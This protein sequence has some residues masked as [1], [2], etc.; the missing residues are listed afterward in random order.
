[1]QSCNRLEISPS[2][3]RWGFWPA[4]LAGALGGFLAFILS[5]CGTAPA[6]PDATGRPTAPPTLGHRIVAEARQLIG[7]PYRYGGTTPRGFDC[8]GLVYYTHRR[9]G[10]SVPR[11]TRA[12][13]DQARPVLPGRLRPGDLVFFRLSWRKVSHV[14]IY[15][16]KGRFIHAPSSGKRVSMASLDNEYWEKRLVAAGRFYG[17]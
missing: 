5:G 2:N 11:S 8:S 9:V 13:L 10:L 4:F 14:G 15:A 7:T 1:M 6:T 16:G 12:Q 17:S 3:R